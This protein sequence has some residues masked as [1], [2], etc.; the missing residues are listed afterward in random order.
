MDPYL[1][2]ADTEM[3]FNYLPALAHAPGHPMRTL[4]SLLVRDLQWT[5]CGLVPTAFQDL[6]LASGMSTGNV[7]KALGQHA[8]HTIVWIN[9]S[10]Q[11]NCLALIAEGAARQAAN[12]ARRIEHDAT[13]ALN[14]VAGVRHRPAP[15]PAVS[16]TCF[17]APPGDSHRRF[18]GLRTLTAPLVSDFFLSDRPT[19]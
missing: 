14:Q 2:W 16:I 18:D 12:E 10:W 9:V 7:A 13:L 1:R 15:G 11:R 5:H 4:D 3:G 6:L 17:G 19:H 8:T